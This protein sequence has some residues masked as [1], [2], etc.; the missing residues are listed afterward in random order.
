MR[1][2]FVDRSKIKYESKWMNMNK[3]LL[4]SKF[5][6][7]MDYNQSWASRGKIF[8]IV[9]LL[10]FSPYL[11]CQIHISTHLTLQS[12]HFTKVFVDKG[13]WKNCRSPTC[14]PNKQVILRYNLRWQLDKYI[15]ILQSCKKIMANMRQSACVAHLFRTWGNLHFQHFQSRINFFLSILFINMLKCHEMRTWKVPK[16]NV[17][18]SD[19]W[20]LTTHRCMSEIFISRIS[21]L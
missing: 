16:S 15:Y 12:L 6:W 5:K 11:I 8:V 19:I 7:A 17:F 9:F 13:P 21:L 1:G 4:K 14:W 2:F 3:I 10:N 20:D 18:P